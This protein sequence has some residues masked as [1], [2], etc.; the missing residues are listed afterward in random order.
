MNKYTSK[1]R[2]SSIGAFN[3]L[4]ESNNKKKKVIWGLSIVALLSV[5]STTG[6]LIFNNTGVSASEP[7]EESQKIEDLEQSNKDLSDLIENMGADKKALEEKI[8]ELETGKANLKEEINN[9]ETDKKNLQSKIT[10]LE[11][12]I[13]TNQSSIG[14]LNNQINS[15]DKEISSLRADKLALEE[16][17]EDNAEVINTLNSNIEELTNKKLTLESQ[18]ADKENI[19]TNLQSEVSSLQNEV[20]NL[21]N[22]ISELNQGQYELKVDNVN[23]VMTRDDYWRMEEYTAD[24]HS[25]LSGEDVEYDIVISQTTYEDE[26][27]ISV[28]KGAIYYFNGTS[29]NGAYAVRYVTIDPNTDTYVSFYNNEKIDHYYFMNV[30]D[31]FDISNHRVERNTYLFDTDVTLRSITITAPDG[32]RYSVGGASGVAT[33]H[34]DLEGNYY[35]SATVDNS[36]ANFYISTRTGNVA[37]IPTGFTLVDEEWDSEGNYIVHMTNENGEALWAKIKRSYFVNYTENNHSMWPQYIEMSLGY[38]HTSGS[39]GLGKCGF[40]FTDSQNSYLTLDF[41]EA[42]LAEMYQYFMDNFAQ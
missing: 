10:E 13:V 15:L 30:G 7:T 28:E 27:G 20:V 31:V 36:W 1:N 29:E 25:T 19:I 23:M 24:I 40:N 34:L 12:R 35:V 42:R 17:A 18:V 16:N 6:L 39:G 41:Y 37:T 2:N 8:S 4:K 5:L 32:Q 21:N 26:N 38:S 22:Q 33:L 14:S 9:L 3:Q 11:A